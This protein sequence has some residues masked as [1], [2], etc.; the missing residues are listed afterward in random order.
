MDPAAGKSPD[1]APDDRGRLS[2]LL[3]L[4]PFA[5][6]YRGLV[7]LTFTGALLASLA[8]L[9][10]PL[11]TAAVI[12]GPIADGNRAGL[13]P[14]VGLALVFGIAD[15]ARFYLRRWAMNRSCLQIERDL[16]D[17][18]YG[19]LQR[20]PVAFHDRWASGQLLCRAT[21]DVS[22]IRRFVGFAAVFLAVNL[23]IC[24]VVIVLL[25]VTY[26]PLGLAVLVT[27]LPLTAL[28]LDRKSVV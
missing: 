3:R 1:A 19:R 10:V 15:A 16:R 25:L 27:T 7:V 24:A 12:D 22:T 9:T 5:R 21:T 8:Q 18:V 6:P 11:V 17:S 14:L 4:V 28:G 23:V 2:A 26:W 20:L 13:V